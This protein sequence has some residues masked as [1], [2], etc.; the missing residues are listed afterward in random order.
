VVTKA[1]DLYDEDF[2]AWTQQQAAALRTHFT[3]DNRL[4][5]EHLAEEVEDLGKSELHAVESFIEH[6]VAHLLKLDYSGQAA[7]RAHWRAEIV[8]F[9]QSVD[10][11]I[12][13]SIRGKVVR[14][15]DE[16][17][18]RARQTAAVGALAHEP[19]LVR[20][21]PKSCPYDWNTIWHRDVLAE[22]G[23]DL[24]D[25]ESSSR[26]PSRGTTSVGRKRVLVSR[27]QKNK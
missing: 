20:R 7:P 22:A 26:R 14:E 12:S 24:A 1:A 23:V 25:S 11:K 21:L 4:D 15:L 16:L 5:V 9:R 17:Y 10:R 6:I 18:R 19:D 3:G 13:P 2:Y 8:N 27:S